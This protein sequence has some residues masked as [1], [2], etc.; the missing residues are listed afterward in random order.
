MR[1]AALLVGVIALIVLASMYPAPMTSVEEIPI[2][3]EDAV[4]FANET[5]VYLKLRIKNVAG[6]P[7]WVEYV[8]YDLRDWVVDAIN[9]QQVE[10]EIALSDIIQHVIETK[11]VVEVNK[12]LEG[13]EEVL[14]VK[15]GVGKYDNYTITAWRG[16]LV[17]DNELRPLDT[18]GEVRWLDK[19]AKAGESVTV[20]VTTKWRILGVIE[21]FRGEGVNVSLKNLEE[22][23]IA[24]LKK[25]LS[26]ID[27]NDADSVKAA[28]MEVFMEYA[29]ELWQMT[30]NGSLT[31]CYG[32]CYPVDTVTAIAREGRLLLFVNIDVVW[33]NPLAEIM[34]EYNA[35]YRELYQ[36]GLS[37]TYNGTDPAIVT[38]RYYRVSE[39]VIVRGVPEVTHPGVAVIFRLGGHPY[40]VRAAIASY[41][42][43]QGLEGIWP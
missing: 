28:I 22:E 25:R 12:P 1:T 32:D 39:E 9:R 2:R 19:P 36:Y 3:I 6:E 30:Y 8:A 20:V 14:I 13:R 38:E 29:K 17:V 40:G 35:V 18:L 43:I 26:S 42:K 31:L 15:L 37:I 24:R 23:Y 34:G 27:A 33:A 5:G 16:K 10:Q 41:A 4:I 7:V 11:K 21:E